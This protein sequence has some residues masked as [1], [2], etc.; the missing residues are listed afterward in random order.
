VIA[1]TARDDSP[2]AIAW[3]KEPAKNQWFAWFAAFFGWTPMLIAT[4]AGCLCAIAALLVSPETMRCGRTGS[5]C[6]GLGERYVSKAQ[7]REK[8]HER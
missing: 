4:W 8:K 3:W 1:A 2:A 7:Y 5:G 6:G